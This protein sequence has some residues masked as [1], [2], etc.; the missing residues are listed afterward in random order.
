[1]PLQLPTELGLADREVEDD[2]NVLPPVSP[3]EPQTDPQ[4]N[5]ENESSDVELRRYTRTVVALERYM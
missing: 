1:M 2:T 5:Q 4:M 3:P